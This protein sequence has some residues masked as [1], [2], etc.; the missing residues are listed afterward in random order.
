MYLVSLGYLNTITRN[1]SDTQLPPPPP[2]MAQEARGQ[3]RNSSSKRRRSVK[4]AKI[5]E[6]NKW[7]K[8][9]AKLHEADVERKRQI[10][11]VADFLK[12]VLPPSSSTF[13]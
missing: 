7:V 12:Q 8:V 1:N 3:E 11:T 5:H 2:K 4:N 6:Y 10:K 9:R 13:D